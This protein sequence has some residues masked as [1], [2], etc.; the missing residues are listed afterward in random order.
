MARPGVTKQEVYQAANTIV[1]KQRIPNVADIRKLLGRGSANTIQKYF[2]N[3]KQDCYQ[4]GSNLEGT[5]LAKHNTI[6]EENK[7]LRQS[8]TKQTN[9]NEE[10]AK[11]LIQTEQ[12]ATRIRETCQ[13]LANELNL[14]REQNI[15]IAAEKDKYKTAYEGMYV[16]R[17][18]AI[19]HMLAEQKQLIGSLRDELREVNIASIEQV[20][21]IGRKG[22]DAL[23]EEKVKTIHLQDELNQQRK[24]IEELRAQL[25]KNQ[26][27]IIPLKKEIE[28]QRKFIQEVISFEQLQQYEQQKQQAEFEGNK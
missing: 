20:K 25:L 3:W 2:K 19:A 10:L 26:E 23:M 17:D 24:T 14:L 18:A 27:T 11:Q 1:A 12:S 5:D 13:S 15:Q 8:L 21:N 16:E 9:K 28:R 4:K 7:N 22:D 6:I